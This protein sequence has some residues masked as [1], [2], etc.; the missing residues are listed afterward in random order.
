MKNRWNEAFDKAEGCNKKF[1]TDKVWYQA[2][3]LLKPSL[4]VA[5]PGYCWRQ[6][7]ALDG[8]L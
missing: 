2:L 4:E 8:F 3:G 5:G 6:E 1:V 7:A